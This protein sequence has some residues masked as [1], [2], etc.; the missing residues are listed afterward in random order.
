VVHNIPSSNTARTSSPPADGHKHTQCAVRLATSDGLY[1]R[2]GTFCH[3]KEDDGKEFIL[4]CEF[5]TPSRES[6]ICFLD[7][8]REIFYT[9]EI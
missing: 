4:I 6:L 3:I 5:M 8:E 7:T 2:K 1:V 9:K